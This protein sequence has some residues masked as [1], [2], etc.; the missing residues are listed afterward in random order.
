MYVMHN[1]I[2]AS[3]TTYYCYRCTCSSLRESCREATIVRDT[4]VV[5]GKTTTTTIEKTEVSASSP[6]GSSLS[7]SIELFE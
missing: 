6:S 7:L 5:L 2:L 1:T 4:G 3:A